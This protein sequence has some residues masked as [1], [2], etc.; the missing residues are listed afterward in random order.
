MTVGVPKKGFARADGTEIYRRN[1]QIYPNGT[2]R[3]PN[4]GLQA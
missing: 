3:Q 2:I 4:T 1:H